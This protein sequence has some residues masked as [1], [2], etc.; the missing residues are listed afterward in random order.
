MSPQ[1]TA[2][3]LPL[4]HLLGEPGGAWEQGGGRPLQ[5]TVTLGAS[6]VLCRWSGLIP[7]KHS[8]PAAPRKPPHV[9]APCVEGRLRVLRKLILKQTGV[10]QSKFVAV[11]ESHLFLV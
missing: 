7:Q 11:S 9:A 3:K 6:T 4:C 10:C 2:Q 1:G 8:H 5:H